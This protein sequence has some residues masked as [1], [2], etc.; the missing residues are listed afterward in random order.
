MNE[1]KAL[2]ILEEA[3][4]TFKA[5]DCVYGSASVHYDELA[6]FQNAFFCNERTPKDVV[7]GN[8]LEKLDRVR[9]VDCDSETFKDSIKDAINY[10]AIAWEV[11]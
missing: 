8:V 9:R 2:T 1:R 10:L 4:E 7:L 3:V 11:S 6:K 5:R